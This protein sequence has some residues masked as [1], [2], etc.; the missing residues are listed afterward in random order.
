MT[1]NE[2]HFNYKVLGLVE[3]YNFNKGCVSISNIFKI[4]KT[5]IFKSK[6]FEMNIRDSKYFQIKNLTTAKLFEIS[7]FNS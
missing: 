2:K 4:L 6:N 7:K 1:L 5:R 3:V